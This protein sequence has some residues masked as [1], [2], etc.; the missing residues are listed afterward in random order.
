VV[1]S[2]RWRER[3][4]QML[5]HDLGDLSYMVERHTKNEDLLQ[6]ADELIEHRRGALKS[7]AASRG[8][9]A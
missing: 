2:A 3:A 7:R 6:R 4:V 5:I 1:R 9:R 8:R